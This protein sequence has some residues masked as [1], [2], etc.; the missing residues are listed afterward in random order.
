[1]FSL[2]LDLESKLAPPSA[3]V[4]AYSTSTTVLSHSPTGGVDS[5]FAGDGAFAACSGVHTVSHPARLN[6]FSSHLFGITGSTGNDPSIAN[7]FP[8]KLKAPFQL[9]Q[10]VL[11]LDPKKFPSTSRISNLLCCQIDQTGLK[12]L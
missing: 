5:E 2:L 3:S 12:F 9:Q 6:L 11:V 10:D 8:S 7:I 4:A 1:M